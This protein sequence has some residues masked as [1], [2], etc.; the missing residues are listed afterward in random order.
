MRDRERHGGGNE[1][2][3]QQQ[4]TDIMADHGVSRSFTD[5]YEENAHA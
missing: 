5:L 3:G 1:R 4:R 2:A